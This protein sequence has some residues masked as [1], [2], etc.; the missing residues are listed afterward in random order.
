MDTDLIR[1]FPRRTKWTPNDELAFVG[2]PP[3]FRPEQQPVK[4]SVTFTW[5]IPE[6]ERLYRAWSDYYS[7]VE[8]GGPAFDD[9]GDKFIPGRFI[10]NGVVFTSRGCPKDCPWCFVQERE[11][12]IR[13]LPITQGHIVQDNNLLACSIQ[14][15]R[16]VFDMLRSQKHSAEFM[17]MDAEFLTTEHIKLLNSIRVDR[18]FFAYDHMGSTYHIEKAADLLGGYNRDKK[19]CYVLVGY[20]PED[21]PIKA[22]KR[23]LKIWELGFM[24]YSMF[25]RDD[26]MKPPK[27]TKEWQDL[28]RIFSRPAIMRGY[29]KQHFLRQPD[30]DMTMNNTDTKRTQI[31]G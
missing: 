1:V 26:T 22:E 20:Y 29:C 5:D 12:Q 14:H 6:A 2:N 21:S 30:K 9:S 15:V 24:P 7:D 13:E 31:R 19:R 8:L 16:A 18:M 27:K 4:I 10:K 17:G 3:L 23:L 11:G 28:T 25:Y